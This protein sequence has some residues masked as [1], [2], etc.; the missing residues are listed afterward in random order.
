MKY[1]IVFLIILFQKISFAQPGML[2]LANEY[3]SSGEYKKAK[4]V[5]EDLLKDESKMDFIY[6]NYLQTLYNLKELELAQKFLKK[7][8]KKYPNY[9]IYKLDLIDC[10]EKGA[11]PEDA[12]KVKNKYAIEISRD[13]NSL[14]LAYEYLMGQRK[15]AYAETL[16]LKARDYER[17]QV[18][19]STQLAEIYQN[20]AQKDKMFDEM[21]NQ[22]F[23]E[24]NV[25]RIKSSFQN[26]IQTEEDFNTFEGLLLAKV[27]QN[28]ENDNL[29][30]V[31]IWAYVQQKDFNSAFIYAKAIDNRNKLQGFQLLDLAKIAMENKAYDAVIKMSDYVKSKYKGIGTYFQFKMMGTKA[32]EELIKNT[33]PIPS[34][35]IWELINEYKSL[36]V[37]QPNSA[38]CAEA[39]RSQALLYAFQ[40]GKIDT[41][42]IQLQE[43]TKYPYFD[44][45][46]KDKCKLDLGDFY[47]LKEEYWEASLIYSQVEKSQ[48]DSPL[49]YEAKL[50]NGKLF[51]YKGEFELAKEQ[52]DVLKLATSREIANDAMDKSIFIQDN[53]GEDTLGTEL[54]KITSIELF[55]FQQKYQEAIDAY[56]SFL[57]TYALSTLRDDAFYGLAKLYI[58]MGKYNEAVDQLIKILTLHKNEILADDAQFLL[59]TLYEEKLRNNEKAMNEY[60]VI[61]LEYTGSIYQAEARKRYRFLRGDK[62]N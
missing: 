6:N 18:A 52:L 34:S 51:Y 14:L 20:L 5:Y 1:I 29:N 42:I 45:A 8:V 50:R 10:I 56:I 4:V 19:Y 16:L 39:I 7:T 13:K 55:I 12:E 53:L 36:C 46:F 31:L 54:S 33:Y 15:Y 11:H 3:Y 21:L 9:V 2:Q 17:D 44:Q 57:T 38:Q 49:A 24:P 37:E 40:L 48:K 43:L 58:K 28:P 27:E 41:A 22:L 61:L 60:N 47:I 35:K 25:E 32:K 62:L 23:A 26:L 30:E 59:A